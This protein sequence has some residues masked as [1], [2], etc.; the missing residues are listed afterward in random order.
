[1]TQGDIRICLFACKSDVPKATLQ[2]CHTPYFRSPCAKPQNKL[3]C[4][5]TCHHLLTASIVTLRAKVHA[6]ANVQ[7]P[8]QCAW[9]L[10]ASSA[11]LTLRHS[12]HV[13]DL[14]KFAA[15]IAWMH[16]CFYHAAQSSS[17]GLELT[18]R[19]PD[20]TARLCKVA[21]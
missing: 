4:N 19:M 6:C 17:S 16:F 21:I 8:I 1:M 18:L 5:S 13:F 11:C 14:V 10:S 12:S 7:I 2:V 15:P 20:M 9:Q 3:K